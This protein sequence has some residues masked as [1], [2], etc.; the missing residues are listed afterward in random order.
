MK[1]TPN[2]TRAVFQGAVDIET[3]G[4]A[5]FASQRTTGSRDWDMRPYDGLELTVRR[6]HYLDK[7]LTVTLKDIIPPPE[8][9]G[10]SSSDPSRATELQR[11]EDPKTTISYEC[12]FRPSNPQPRDGERIF[13]PWAA[14]RPTYRGRREDYD[15]VPELNLACVKRMSFMVRS[16]FGKQSGPFQLTIIGVAAV[17]GELALADMLNQGRYELGSRYWDEYDERDEEELE[18]D[19][20]DYASCIK[21]EAVVPMSTP[22]ADR[23]R[24]CKSCVVQ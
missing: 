4:G 6:G 13:V 12:N 7:L 11:R 5:G 19:E 18:A 23:R 20:D 22:R 17:T 3:L 10:L 9:D 1:L 21:K 24:I 15:V 8:L 16:F 14:F 2:R